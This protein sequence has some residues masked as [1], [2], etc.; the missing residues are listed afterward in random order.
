[1]EKNHIS[2]RAKQRYLKPCIW[3][4]EFIIKY[5]FVLKVILGLED[6][7][8]IHGLHKTEIG[9]SND[10]GTQSWRTVKPCK[11]YT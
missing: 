11:D 6:I 9:C 1:M 2:E 4:Y 5:G 7:L 8:L 10:L 3:R